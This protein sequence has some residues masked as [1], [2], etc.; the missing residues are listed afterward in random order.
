MKEM[1][2]NEGDGEGGGEPAQ[3]A[4]NDNAV[5]EP[6]FSLKTVHS[7]D[8]YVRGYLYKTAQKLGF[9]Q[10]W[11]FL[12]RYYELNKQTQVMTVREK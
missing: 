9:M 1:R 11:F 3:T 12:R 2:V 10:S 4:V 5:T 7:D 8:T 6:H